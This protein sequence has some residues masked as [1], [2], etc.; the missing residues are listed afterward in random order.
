M[1]T[2]KLK[3]IFFSLSVFV[4][5]IFFFNATAQKMVETE[6]ISEY[7][8]ATD[9]LN[10]IKQAVIND[11]NIAEQD[12]TKIFSKDEVNQTSLKK[13]GLEYSGA[14]TIFVTGCYRLMQFCKPP[15]GDCDY[16][17]EDVCLEN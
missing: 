9:N 7:F 6:E 8:S 3:S 16:Y 11:N 17:W 12:L 2:L 10:E 13:T 14:V 15:F 5:L 1:K 4:L